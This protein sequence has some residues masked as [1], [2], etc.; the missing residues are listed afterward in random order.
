MQSPGNSTNPSEQMMEKLA[1]SIESIFLRDDYHDFFRVCR[2]F[3]LKSPQLIHRALDNQYFD[4][5]LKFLPTSL[6]EILQK[7][8]DH[9]ETFLLH[10]IRLDHLKIIQAILTK[11]RFEVLLDATDNHQ[12]NLFHIIALNSISS[13]TI[14]WLVDHFHEHSIDI[15]K[16]FDHTN[17]DHWTPLQLAIQKNNLLATKHFLPYFQTDVSDTKNSTGDNLIHLAVRYGDLNLVKYLIEDGKLIEQG[18]FSNLIMN[19]VE[20][21]RSLQHDDMIDYFERIYPEEDESEEDDQ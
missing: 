18:R 15:V 7:T 13:E 6:N 12:N 3:L 14:Q 5:L 19:P 17:D 8:N 20:L 11:K 9:G 10:A 21:A 4:L 1:S 2:A 16:R